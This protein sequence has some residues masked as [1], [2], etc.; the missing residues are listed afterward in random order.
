MEKEQGLQIIEQ[1]LNVANSKGVFK[2]EESA[3][4]YAAF[5]IV[6]NSLQEYKDNEELKNTIS[7]LENEKNI[8]LNTINR[9]KESVL[10]LS[11]NPQVINNTTV[12]KPKLEK[13]EIRTKSK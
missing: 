12:I 9:L 3:T 5:T 8:N 2:L 7:N 10:E 13:E 1:A 4:I 6:K 11:K